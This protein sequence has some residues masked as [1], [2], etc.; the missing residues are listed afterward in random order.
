[1]QALIANYDGN[2]P[3]KPW[4]ALAA[5]AF[6]LN[7]GAGKTI[8]YYDSLP[9]NVNSGNKTSTSEIEASSPPVF[10]LIHG[11]GDEADSWRHIIPLLSGRGFRTLAIDL[12]GFGRSIS[13]GRI[14]VK[15]HAAA[16]IKLIEAVLKIPHTNLS[17]EAATGCCA[18]SPVFLAGNSL[19]ALVA[20]AAA[21]K[22]PDLVQGIVLI[23][24]SIPGGPENPGPIALAKLLFNR[25]W[26]RAYRGKPHDAWA[27]L[28]PYYADLDSMSSE[29]KEFLKERVI[30]RVESSSQEKAFFATQRSLIRTFIFS[31]SSLAR[32]IRHNPGKILLIWGKKDRIMPLSSAEK[33]RSIRQDIELK[34]ISGA[35]HLPHQE[36]PEETARLMAEFADFC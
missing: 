4:P 27:S 32:K 19:G 15:S 22:R 8:F 29:D 21:I 23:D 24:G 1:M 2:S 33:I 25:K 3:F 31:S 28:Y 18:E 12:P 5:K 16:V 6:Q 9:G 36:K 35:G 13:T 14:S 26:Y 17:H 34:V 30:A 11:L 10:V 20:E 7:I